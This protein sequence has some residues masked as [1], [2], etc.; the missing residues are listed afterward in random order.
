MTHVGVFWDLE[1]VPVPRN[2]SGTDLVLALSDELCRFG[3]PLSLVAC[4][5]LAKIK[6]DVRVQ[7][8]RAGVAVFDAV[9]AGKKDVADKMLV[10]RMFE[11]ALNHKTATIV[12]ISGDVDFAIALSVLRLHGYKIVVVL[13]SHT[14]TR[15]ELKKLAHKLYRVGDI[16]SPEEQFVPP[17]PAVVS[18]V[19]LQGRASASA[20]SSDDEIE[21]TK[22]DDDAE[23]SAHSAH[24]LSTRGVEDHVTSFMDAVGD[25]MGGNR[26]EQ[27]I[28]LV[29]VGKSLTDRWPVIRPEMVKQLAT[30]AAEQGWIQLIKQ[31]QDGSLVVAVPKRD[32]KTGEEDDGDSEDEDDDSDEQV[33]VQNNPPA[34]RPNVNARVILEELAA[35][36]CKAKGPAFGLSPARLCAIYKQSSGRSLED[37]LGYT[38]AK[39]RANLSAHSDLFRTRYRQGKGTTFF[40]KK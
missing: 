12:L 5:N 37:A 32:S 38:R 26:T 40:V 2:K 16:L 15:D 20:D 14:D 29:V 31:S 28:P 9:H 18:T 27:L 35:L 3:R 36:A 1:N 19:A 22:K 10:S 30:Y 7:L 23:L 21:R 24:S 8:E 33:Q 39:F 6:P 34:A 4:A 11:F 25:C 17:A 13:P